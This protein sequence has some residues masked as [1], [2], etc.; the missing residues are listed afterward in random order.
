[1]DNPL[2]YWAVKSS[3]KG[4]NMAPRQFTNFFPQPEQG[5]SQDGA[6]IS[7]ER[8]A[9]ISTERAASQPDNTDYSCIMDDSPSAA[10]SSREGLKWS[11]PSPHTS[12]MNVLVRQK[13]HKAP[14][15]VDDYDCSVSVSLAA[16]SITDNLVSE[17]N[18]Q[19]MLM[20]L[21]K[22]QLRNISSTIY[23]LQI[24]IDHNSRISQW[25]RINF[26]MLT[27]LTLKTCNMLLTDWKT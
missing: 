11:A 19:H 10:L 27:N 18:L 25:R 16:F 17:K 15:L 9:P 3:K 6:A 5:S 1:M 12:S 13:Q 26:W 22:D 2:Y 24:H 14:S 21:Q 4:K 20:T 7:T 23:N 8:A